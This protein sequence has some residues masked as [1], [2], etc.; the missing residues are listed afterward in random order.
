MLNENPTDSE[1]L[2]RI[3]E[4]LCIEEWTPDTLGLIADI[5]AGTDRTTFVEEN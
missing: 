3:A 1:A 2:D 4:I 5:V